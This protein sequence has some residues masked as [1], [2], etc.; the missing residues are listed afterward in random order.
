M[1]KLTWMMIACLSPIALSACGDDEDS[2]GAPSAE[3]GA[4]EAA[5]IEE[6]TAGMRA[7]ASLG[8]VAI[9]APGMQDHSLRDAIE[10]LL[11]DRID[12]D[13]CL[14]F[15]RAESAVS[16]TFDACLLGPEA[17]PVDG[18]A[19][20]GL[21]FDP[22]TLSIG[23]EALSVD[24]RTF[25]GDVVTTVDDEAGLSVAADLTLSGADGSSSLALESVSLTVADGAAV[26]DGA[27]TITS[28]EIS[29]GLGLSEI[30]WVSG[31]CLPISGQLSYTAEGQAKQ[32]TFLEETPETGV[33]LLKV[34]N[35]PAVEVALLPPCP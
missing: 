1:S 16:V 9:E 21:T 5:M 33:V 7:A 13:R 27:A 3:V 12:D 10:A 34:G 11:V 6:A 32:I 22:T 25:D 30:T 24:G 35:L 17:V 18:A 31:S 20:V 29:S 15:G 2:E 19:A 26:L 23:L 28:A 4:S 8:P 14:S